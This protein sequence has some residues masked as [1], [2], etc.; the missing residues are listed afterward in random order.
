MEIKNM[1]LPTREQAEQILK[2]NVTE[3]YLLLHSH[4]VAKGMEGYA[5]KFGE[6]K[7]G[8][9]DLWYITGLLH[10]LD[11]QKY[12]EV[13]PAES[14][15]WFTEWG[16]PQELIDAV[17]AHGT[18]LPRVE[19]KTMLAKTLVATDELCGLIYAY[20]LMRP[21]GMAGMEAKSVA[22]KF[23]DKAFAAK[24]S[25][26]EIQYGVDCMGVEL[27]EHIANLLEFKLLD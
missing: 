17:E 23:K 5:E 24:I 1:A 26:E 7:M 11:Y 18:D 9:S 10:D 25:R 19:P 22:K 16:Y 27:N 2:E 20:S 13:H 14:L 6:A 15:K 4:M 12:P 21:T 3:T 8:N